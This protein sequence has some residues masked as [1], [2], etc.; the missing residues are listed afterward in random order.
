MGVFLY[1]CRQTSNL[2]PIICT[3][4]HLA[5]WYWNILE[6][7]V[8]IMKSAWENLITKTCHKWRHSPSITV[9]IA[10]NTLSTELSDL[11]SCKTRCLPEAAYN[12][13]AKEDPSFFSWE[14]SE[15]GMKMQKM[16]IGS[17]KRGESRTKGYREKPITGKKTVIIHSSNNQ[18]N[19]N[20]EVL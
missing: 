10:W 12:I 11:P 18:N 4:L 6:N 15:K 2:T 7:T 5:L 16:K 8:T 14:K 9:R 1:R 13:S 17:K 19:S 20:V 3:R